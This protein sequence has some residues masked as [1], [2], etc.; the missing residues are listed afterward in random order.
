MDHIFGARSG[1]TVTLKVTSIPK[2]DLF[3]FSLTGDGFEIETDH[4]SYTEYSFIA[5][6]T[7]IIWYLYRIDRQ[8]LQQKLNFFSC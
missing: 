1:Q 3:D 8:K 7:E 6:E 2:G 5:P 4:N